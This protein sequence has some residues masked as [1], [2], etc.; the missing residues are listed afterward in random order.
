[1]P[2]HHHHHHFD[3]SA[4]VSIFAGVS[5]IAAVLICFIILTRSAAL[6][7]SEPA[8]T[9]VHLSAPMMALAIA[10][11]VGS[12]AGVHWFK[13]ETGARHLGA[14]FA[15][16]IAAAGVILL[17]GSTPVATIAAA[18]AGGALG[19]AIVT[20]SL[21]LRPSIHLRKLGTWCGLGAGIAYAF[22]NQPWV[23]NASPHSQ[24]IISIVA[25]L[26][27]LG[28]SLR[29]TGEPTKPSSSP[30]YNPFISSLWVVLFFVIVSA[31]A[32]AAYTIQGNPLLATDTWDGAIELQGNAFVYLCT[33]VIAGLALDRRQLALT[34][35]TGLLLLAGACLFLGGSVRFFPATRVF[36][37]ASAAIFTTALFYY[38]GRGVRPWLTGTLFAIV[39]WF[40]TIAGLGLTGPL[41]TTPWAFTVIMG[42][43]A[44]AIFLTRNLWLKR[45]HIEAGF[46]RPP[47]NS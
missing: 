47:L 12:L 43:A 29:L 3:Q 14:G 7:Q 45:L 2:S 46:S 34:L 6:D 19:W 17:G 36:H 20:L 9:I 39:Y 42:I 40:G 28:V 26:I 18:L 38:A 23:F 5:A 21:C 37:T 44:S 10:G 27:G 30:D 31:C 25:A 8:A 13:A 22:M 4:A 24:T 15:V 41:Q 35:G 32:A 33:A 1:M 16:Y 11:F